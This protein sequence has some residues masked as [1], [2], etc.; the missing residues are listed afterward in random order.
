MFSQKQYILFDLDGTLTDPVVGITKSVQYALGAFGIEVADPLSLRHFIGP[1]L[2]EAFEEHYKFSREQAEKAV[3]KYRERFSTVGI[4][5]N[6]VYEGIPGL[7]SDLHAQGKKLLLATSKPEI[8]AKQILE[9]FGLASYFTFIGGSELNG[10]RTHKDDVIRYVLRAAKVVSTNDA[11][12]VGDRK[13]D[14][15]GAH[16]EGLVCIGVLYGHGGQEEL[17]EAGADAI[18]GDVAELGRL[19]TGR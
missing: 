4:F 11:V 8:Y 13:Y 12:M 14:V 18:A 15:L 17:W 5:E 19:L 16:K 7:L 2:L 3:L 10:D 1:P 6:E 9:H